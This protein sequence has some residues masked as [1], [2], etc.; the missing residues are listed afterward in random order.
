MAVVVIALWSSTVLERAGF[1][2]AF[3]RSLGVEVWVAEV[4]WCAFEVGVHQ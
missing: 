4:L 3:G 2:K 1:V